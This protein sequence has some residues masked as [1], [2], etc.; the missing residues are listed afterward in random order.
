MTKEHVLYFQSAGPSASDPAPVV[1]GV[2]T[3]EHC[4]KIKSILM[5]SPDFMAML[6]REPHGQLQITPSAG[7]ARPVPVRIRNYQSRV[8]GIS[9]VQAV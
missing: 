5:A 8:A 1:L 4:E 6:G 9:G 2:G 7:A 3:R